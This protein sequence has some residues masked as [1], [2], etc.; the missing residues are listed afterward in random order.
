MRLYAAKD[1]LPH[2]T[3]EKIGTYSEYRMVFLE[4]IAIL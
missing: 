2:A 4:K 1:S 3:F